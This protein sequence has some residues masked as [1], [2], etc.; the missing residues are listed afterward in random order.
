MSRKPE[1]GAD[2]MIVHL[3][4]RH[5][6]QQ[7]RVRVR[8]PRRPEDVRHELVSGEAAEGVE[9]HVP[10]PRVEG[11]HVPESPTGHAVEEQ[12][13]VVAPDLSVHGDVEVLRVPCDVDLVDLVVLPLRVVPGLLR[14]PA[15][16]EAEDV[17]VRRNEVRRVAV[18]AHAGA[19]VA[20]GARGRRDRG[21]QA[22][23]SERK[24]SEEAHGAVRSVESREVGA[25]MPGRIM[26]AHPEGV[27][28]PAPADDSADETGTA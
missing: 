8:V 21:K 9:V 11:G 12:D 27:K 1:L 5:L 22:E 18:H 7:P 6:R 23:H 4:A 13:H 3:V 20:G 10:S 17:L 16:R 19:E 15:G 24:G 25:K 28:A 14:H 2:Q 26:R